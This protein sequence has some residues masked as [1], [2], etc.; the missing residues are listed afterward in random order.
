MVLPEGRHGRPSFL[1]AGRGRYAI[2][3]AINASQATTTHDDATWGGP[4]GRT[5]ATEYH[6][7]RGGSGCRAIGVRTIRAGGGAGGWLGLRE[8]DDGPGPGQ[9]LRPAGASGQGQRDPVAVQLLLDLR[10]RCG[11]MSM[12]R[13][14]I[15]AISFSNGEMTTAISVVLMKLISCSTRSACD[16][17][18]VAA[19]RSRPLMTSYGSQRIVSIIVR[20]AAS[21]PY[22]ASVDLAIASATI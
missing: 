2:I 17:V 8:P 3:A 11:L 15:S 4:Y 14:A 10:L 7:R 13:P 21:V 16:G 20:P 6:D 22:L 5:H 18:K 9:H 19:S 12:P 1:P